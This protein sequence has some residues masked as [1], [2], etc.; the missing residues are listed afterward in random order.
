[1]AATAIA[2]SDV[3]DAL[4]AEARIAPMRWQRYGGRMA[5]HGEVAT[6]RC[7]GSAGLIRQCIEEAGQGRV[8]VV[9]AGGDLLVA[10]LGDRMA[11]IAQRNGWAGLVIHGAVRD[12]DALRQM[13]V[14]VF[15][16]GATPLRGNFELAGERD[17]SL[18]PGD[19]QVRPGEHVFCDGDGIVVCSE[20]VAQRV[21]A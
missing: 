5:F 21:F 15:A 11:A 10:V 6:V 12:V 18:T 9:D 8:L 20:N 14:G 17:V 13:D 7:R 16:L 4:G 2:T 1:M 19:L 3:A